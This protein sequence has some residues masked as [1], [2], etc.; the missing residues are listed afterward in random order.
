MTADLFADTPKQ[1]P[2]L[3]PYWHK[4]IRNL[5]E[6]KTVAQCNNWLQLHFCVHFKQLASLINR[7]T[8]AWT[9]IYLPLKLE[10]QVT[11]WPN[12]PFVDYQSLISAANRKCYPHSTGEKKAGKMGLCKKTTSRQ[13]DHSWLRWEGKK[14]TFFHFF[15][16][17]SQTWKNWVPTE[18]SLPS[19]YKTVNM[20]NLCSGQNSAVQG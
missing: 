9:W 10:R 11:F 15:I 12:I 6:M 20:S 7:W 3:F 13:I 5:H 16:S 1:F 4:T 14:S 2:V 19:W 17:N 18:H 8:Y